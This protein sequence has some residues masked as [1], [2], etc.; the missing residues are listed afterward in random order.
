MRI[1]SYNPYNWH[2]WF[3]WRPVKIGKTIYWLEFVERERIDM[4]WCYRPIEAKT[5]GEA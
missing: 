4:M 5:E 1:E 2:K 3:A